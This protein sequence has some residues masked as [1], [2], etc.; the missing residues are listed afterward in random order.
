M[1]LIKEKIIKEHHFYTT[2]Q[3]TSPL[4]KEVMMKIFKNLKNNYKNK[5]T[6]A[7]NLP[8]SLKN[9]NKMKQKTRSKS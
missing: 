6:T 9:I 8:Y 7:Q 2:Q 5:N 4:L 1:D 3:K